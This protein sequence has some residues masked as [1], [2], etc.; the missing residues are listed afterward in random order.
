MPAWSKQLSWFNH[1]F[2]ATGCHGH[3]SLEFGQFGPLN[4]VVIL[5]QSIIFGAGSEGWPRNF[6]SFSDSHHN[7]NGNNPPLS[8]HPLYT[9]KSVV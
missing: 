7:S 9:I 8:L 2:H 1:G 5:S 6:A 4:A 3:L